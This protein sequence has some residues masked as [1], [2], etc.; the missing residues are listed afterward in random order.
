MSKQ[1][2]WELFDSMLEKSKGQIYPDFCSYCTIRPSVCGVHLMMLVKTTWQSSWP[3]NL[4]WHSQSCSFLTWIGSWVVQGF[5]A[6][7]IKHHSFKH[8]LWHKIHSLPR[9]SQFWCIELGIALKGMQDKC[10]NTMQLWVLYAIETCS[11]S[12]SCI[13]MSADCPTLITMGR[14]LLMT[15]TGF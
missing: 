2:G 4:L 10:L 3:K 15:L 14:I 7:C 13:E 12:P 5:E 8:V 6:R 9:L 11:S 1:H